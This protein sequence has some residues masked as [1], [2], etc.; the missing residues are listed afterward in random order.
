MGIYAQTSIEIICKNKTSVKNVEKMIKKISKNSD[1]N[2][3]SYSNLIIYDF[4]VT[5]FKDSG[6]VQNLEYQCD[7]LWGAIKDIK[8][9]I[10]MTCPFLTEDSGKYYENI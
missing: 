6:R 1:D 3:Y 2:N 10:E 9:V 4:T 7:I 5:L 8:G